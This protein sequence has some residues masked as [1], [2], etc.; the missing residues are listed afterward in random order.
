[1][2]GGSE[3]LRVDRGVSQ[4]ADT[5]NDTSTSL[6]SLLFPGPKVPS[7]LLLEMSGGS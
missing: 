5:A 4:I 1:M 2:S 3:S 6:I 7:R